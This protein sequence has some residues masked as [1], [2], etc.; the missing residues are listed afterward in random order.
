[1]VYLV[2]FQCMEYSVQWLTQGPWHIC[3]LRYYHF[4]VLGVV[5]SP[6]A[7]IKYHDP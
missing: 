3:H 4:F 7:V 2:T 1:M 6:S 5:N